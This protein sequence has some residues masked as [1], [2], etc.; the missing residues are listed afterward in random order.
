MNSSPLVARIEDLPYYYSPPM[1]ITF[2][3]KAVLNAGRY[4]FNG[5]REAIGNNKNIND[6]TLLYI[7]SMSFNADV[8][9]LNY[10]RALKLNDGTVD[11]PRFSLFAESDTNAPVFIDP[12]QLT[13]YFY[14]QQYKKLLLMAQ[15]PNRLTG[16]FRGS[17]QQHG[18]IA[19]VSEITMTINVWIQS[20]T[21][22][23]FIKAL[24]SRYPNIGRV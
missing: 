8:D 18:G 9:L 22:D 7:K 4:I 11:I 21:D 1:Q 5:A 13:D 12:I 23:N 15:T 19:G 2:K 16:F 17:L 3:Q 20:I 14:D 10:Q 24:K 6:L